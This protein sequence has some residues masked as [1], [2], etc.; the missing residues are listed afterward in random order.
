MWTVIKFKKGLISSLIS[1]L[2]EKLG[3]DVKIY[4][5]KFLIRKYKQNKK[6]NIEYSL[7]NDYLF[8]F[9]KD[10]NQPSILNKLKFVR[11]LKYF[12]KDFAFSQKQIDNFI[13]ECKKS[14]SNDG[15]LNYNF[16]NLIENKNYKFFSGPFSE[17]IFKIVNL[18]KNKVDILL[19]NLK[20]TIKRKDLFFARV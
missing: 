7:L 14:E 3:E 11:G 5:P 19:G 4:N 18:K 12:I 13:N 1:G 20:S 10:F 2:R 15:Y 16:L 6:I 8:C 9:H 17:K